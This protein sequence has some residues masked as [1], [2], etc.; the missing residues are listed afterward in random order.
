MDDAVRRLCWKAPVNY[1]PYMDPHREKAKV[2]GSV[3]T[4]ETPVTSGV[5]LTPSID[6]DSSI[7]RMDSNSGMDSLFGV[8]GLTSLYISPEEHDGVKYAPTVSPAVSSTIVSPSVSSASSNEIVYD[9]AK[10]CWFPVC[11]IPG[12]TP[13]CRYVLHTLLDQP[14]I[15]V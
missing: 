12:G 9:G 10:S 6:E 3:L 14:L 8:N 7:V 2:S 5:P 11:Q 4:I 15:D 13:C 1:Y